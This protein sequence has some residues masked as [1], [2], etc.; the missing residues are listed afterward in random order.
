M[1]TIDALK[2]RE[3]VKAKG[4]NTV[5]VTLLK[6]DGTQRT[7]NGLFKPTSDMKIDESLVKTGRIP[8][9][10]LAENAWK[11][12]KEHRVLDIA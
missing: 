10:C 8:I 12:F 4:T 11:T 2:V 9:Y 5:T 1:N 6:G 3:I 7:I